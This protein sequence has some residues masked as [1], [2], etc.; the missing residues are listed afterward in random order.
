MPLDQSPTSDF[1][2]DDFDSEDFDTGDAAVGGSTVITGSTRREVERELRRIAMAAGRHKRQ[3]PA[4]VEL[5]EPAM[6]DTALA[7]ALRAQR[8][9]EDE[10]EAAILLLML[11]Q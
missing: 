4:V 10:E 5:V 1:H 9:A 3:T 6:A 11:S 7:D 2:P 8:W